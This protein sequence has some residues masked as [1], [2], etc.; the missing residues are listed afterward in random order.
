MMTMIIT[1]LSSFLVYA[2]IQNIITL[3]LK[4]SNRHNA[5]ERELERIE[6]EKEGKS[7]RKYACAK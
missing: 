3:M 4:N 2:S 7:K 5:C 6:K 1:M